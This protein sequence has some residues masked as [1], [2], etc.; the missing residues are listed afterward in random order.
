MVWQIDVFDGSSF[1]CSILCPQKFHIL[2]NFCF[3]PRIMQADWDHH[4]VCTLNMNLLLAASLLNIANKRKQWETTS[5]SQQ[6]RHTSIT[7]IPSYN[8]NVNKY[9]NHIQWSVP[10]SNWPQI[11]PNV[12]YWAFTK[13][14]L[15][16]EADTQTARKIDSQPKQLSRS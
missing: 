9:A 3:L 4:S 8:T 13:C 14:K 10:I 12:T 6:K 16:Y 2:G 11:Q 7:Y 15:R 5:L 1:L